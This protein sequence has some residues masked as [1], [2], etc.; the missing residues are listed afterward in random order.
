MMYAFNLMRSPQTNNDKTI[1][2][3]AVCNGNLND[4]HQAEEEV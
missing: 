4:L 1:I 2:Q 3:N